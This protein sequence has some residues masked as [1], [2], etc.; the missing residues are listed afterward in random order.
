MQHGAILGRVDVCALPHGIDARA[1]A[2]HVGQ[3][4][5]LGERDLIEPLAR[6]IDKESRV[7]ARQALESPRVAL[8]QLLHRHRR[9]T[10]GMGGE[11]RP[12]RRARTRTCRGWHECCDLR[13][14]RNARSCRRRTVAALR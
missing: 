1:Q 10:R 2:N 4:E 11:L 5:E 6:E 7:L 9:E 14:G 3:L 8:E 12:Y 13:C